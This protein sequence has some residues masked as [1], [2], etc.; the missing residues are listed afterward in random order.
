MPSSEIVDSRL[1]V[2]LDLSNANQLNQRFR[3]DRAYFAHLASQLLLYDRVL[4]PTHDY[5]VV[6]SLIHWM[7]INL[8]HEMLESNALGFI[9][10]R[11][12]FGYLGNGLGINTFQI[13]SRGKPLQWWQESVFAENQRAAELQVAQLDLSGSQK[14]SL[15]DKTL[16]STIDLDY[17]NDFFIDQIT[18]ET[19][20]N[21]MGSPALAAYVWRSSQK[22]DDGGVDLSRLPQVRGDQVRVLRADG[23]IRDPVDLVLRAAEV[24]MEIL[25][26]SQAGGADL[27]TTEG[28]DYVLREKLA[29]VGAN[30][31]ML[32]AFT[33]LLELNSIPDLHPA[34]SKG[35]IALGNVWRLR[36]SRKGAEFREWLR[37]ASPSDARDLER[38]YVASISQEARAD[39][40]PTKAIRFIITTAAGMI[41]GIGGL[42]GGLGTEIAGSFFLDKWINGYSPKL[43][44]DELQKLVPSR[45]R[46]DK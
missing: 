39:K 21:V 41:P 40:W 28:A 14:T 34:I 45:K 8:L 11:G 35:E 33:S 19:Y 16:Q 25:M 6:P 2:R 1:F 23:R 30:A 5:G 36:N 38:A 9:R 10:R 42:L 22:R 17:T 12:L 44:I 27:F 13:Q 29:H 37:N 31:E 24:N 20:R 32:A 26:A 43:F 4:I 3:K 7:D 46:K 15:V 18:N